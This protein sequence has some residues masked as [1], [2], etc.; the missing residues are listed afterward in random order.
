MTKRPEPR[1]DLALLASYHSP[2]VDVEVR[3]ST[4]EAPQGPPVEF[5]TALAEAVAAL[6]LHRYPDRSAEK[7]RNA[8]AQRYG[9]K[10]DE[11]FVANGSNEVLQSL[12]LTYGGPGRSLALFEPTYGMHAQI[13]RTTGTTVLARPR[14]DDF[15][16]A[17]HTVA[18]V[19]EAEQPDVVFLCSPNN[20][21]G[22]QDPPGLVEDTLAQVQSYGG[23][24][25]VDEAYGQ[26]ADQSAVSLIG[27]SRS[28]VVSRTFSKTWALAGVRLGYLLGP[29]WCVSELEKASLPYHLGALTQAAGLLAL[30]YQEEMDARVDFLRSERQRVFSVLKTLPVTVWPSDTNFILFRPEEKEGRVVWQKLLDRSILIRDFSAEPGLAGCLRVTMGTSQENNQFLAALEE[31]LS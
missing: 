4:N 23:L 16:L 20:P 30:D 28:L 27:E 8:L 10:M 18:E 13:A 24:L 25:L 22:T 2:Q 6:P 9:R 29:A 11:V 5:M 17:P 15:S 26:F 19:V 3:L 1:Q 12:L 7:L 31:V 14:Q 21:T